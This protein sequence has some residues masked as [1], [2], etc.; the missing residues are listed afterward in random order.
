MI[1]RGTTTSKIASQG[2]FAIPE[3]LSEW[4]QLLRDHSSAPGV[5]L[6]ILDS[7]LRCVAINQ[8]LAEING[9]PDEAHVGRTIRELLG[10]FAEVI[11][12]YLERVKETG[13]AV[14]HREISVILPTERRARALDRALPTYQGQQREGYTHR[15]GCVGDHRSKASGG[16]APRRL[17][18]LEGP[19]KARACDDRSRPPSGGKMERAADLSESLSSFAQGVAPGI[20]RPLIAR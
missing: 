7:N 5:G 6:Y 1:V 17:R 10:D 16:I 9:I 15:L 12:P 13:L 3:S 18:E 8:T 4:K 14:L 20:R 11:E 19:E 2:L